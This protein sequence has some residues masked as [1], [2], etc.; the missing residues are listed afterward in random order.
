M[1]YL[2]TRF[3][4]SAEAAVGKRSS[5]G[6]HKAAMVWQHFSSA[7]S[8]VLASRKRK[9]VTRGLPRLSLK[10]PTDQGV[11]KF[12]E[13]GPGAEPWS[14]KSLPHIAPDREQTLPAS[15]V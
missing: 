14:G 15:Q 2:A 6:E 5:F 7:G 1:E 13:D 10:M 3:G 8:T 9:P 11:V 4:G 12:S